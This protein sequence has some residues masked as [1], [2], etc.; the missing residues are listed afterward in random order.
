MTA[1]SSRVVGADMAGGD[2]ARPAGAAGGGDE[3]DGRCCR[4]EPCRAQ[5]QEV[6]VA[7]ADTQADQLAA[8]HGFL[9][10]S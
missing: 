4:D 2:L 6:G 9:V 10:T 1:M 7:R 8:T 3:G 5:G